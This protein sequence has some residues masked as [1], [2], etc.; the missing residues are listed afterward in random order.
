MTGS[1][2]ILPDDPDPGRNLL[3]VINI[4]CC[5]HT[6]GTR[7]DPGRDTQKGWPCLF[8]ISNTFG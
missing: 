8:K 6:K 5:W 2:L 7:T 4:A 3:H 1:R